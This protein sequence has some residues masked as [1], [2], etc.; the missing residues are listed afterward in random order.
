MPTN[1]GIWT[2]PEPE[3]LESRQYGATALRG[4]DHGT[5]PGIT[6]HGQCSGPPVAGVQGDHDAGK[7]IAGQ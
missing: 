6:E 4:A 3:G 5:H 7:L 2:S 1:R